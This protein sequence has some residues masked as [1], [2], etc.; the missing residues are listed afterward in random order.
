MRDRY[1]SV[2]GR[3]DPR[4]HSRND[5]EIDYRVIAR[6]RFFASPSEDERISALEPDDALTRSRKLHDEEIDFLL[7]DGL[8]VTAALTDKVQLGNSR[9]FCVRGNDRGIHKRVIDDCVRAFD[10]ILAADSDQTGIA[11]ARSDKKNFPCAQP[12]ASS[13]SDG[14]AS[15]SRGLH[16]T[17]LH[18]DE[19]S[20]GEI[21][22]GLISLRPPQKTFV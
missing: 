20:T 18:H 3:G 13:F 1:S 11:R 14:S 5:L 2:C 7:G 9:L 21:S 8:R 12:P 19:Y 10:E 22:D 17:R 6:L 15:I 16:P 4:C